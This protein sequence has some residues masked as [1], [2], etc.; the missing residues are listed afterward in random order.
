M[1]DLNQGTYIDKIDKT[2]REILEEHVENK[3]NTNK[4]SPRT[5]IR[6]KQTVKQIKRTCSEIFEMPIQKITVY[7]IRRVLPNITIYSNKT[8]DKIYRLINKTFKIAVSDRI[9][10]FNPLDNE[11]ITKPRSNIPDKQIEALTLEQNKKMVEV[12]DREEYKNLKYRNIVLLQLYTGIR[13]GEALA[14]S[15][16]DVD[17]K[18]GTIS[19]RKTMTRDENNHVIIGHTT[20]TLTA[21]RTILMRNRTRSILRD[22]IKEYKKN[23]EAARLDYQKSKSRS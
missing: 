23:W 11:S 15:I 17:F 3:F 14:L 4:V 2:F 6:D 20:K 19:I 16:E 21:K 9:I 10:M 22:A 13:I 8:I 5:Y 1:N 7:H 18:A 12:F